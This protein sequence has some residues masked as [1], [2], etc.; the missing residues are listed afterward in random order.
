MPK[1]ILVAAKCRRVFI[2]KGHMPCMMS[3]KPILTIGVKGDEINWYT[4][5]MTDK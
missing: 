3:V 5:S 4:N 2:K 1:R